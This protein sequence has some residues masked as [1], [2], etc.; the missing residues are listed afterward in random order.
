MSKAM[1]RKQEIKI[2]PKCDF[3]KY[4]DSVATPINQ[5][6]STPMR[7]RT[8]KQHQSAL[9]DFVSDQYFGKTAYKMALFKIQK[10]PYENSKNERSKSTIT[11]LNNQ[12]PAIV[13]S[14]K[15]AQ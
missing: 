12:L 3:S 8:S 2:L 14:F 10:K 7:K 9:Q 15:P 4:Q 13:N 11:K 6:V 1:P 5:E